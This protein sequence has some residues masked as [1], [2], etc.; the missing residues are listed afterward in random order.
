[1][2]DTAAAPAATTR[3]PAFGDL[4]NEL[5]TT[6]RVLERVADEHWDWKPHEKSKSL[7]ALAT[8]VA[9]IPF[10]ASLVLTT[11]EFNAAGANRWP[12]GAPTNR[13]QLLAAFDAAATAVTSAI[14]SVPADGW[15]KTWQLRMGDQ[16]FVSLP[17]AAALRVLG[18]SH[19]V[20]HRAQ[21]TVY[22]RLLNIPV[23][24]VYGPSADEAPAG[25]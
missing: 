5:A 9:E 10:L 8:H 4:E 3:P 15:G 11:D 13:E 24:S 14:G 25:R 21:L 16:V 7:G 18:I 23:P 2:T 19:L 1:M 12:Q 17:R 20:H 6:R 22:L